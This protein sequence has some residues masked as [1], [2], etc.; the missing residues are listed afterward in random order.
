MCI[1]DSPSSLPLQFMMMRSLSE[2]YFCLRRF[3]THAL[4]MDGKNK[5]IDGRKRAPTIV[6][7][8]RVICVLELSLIHISEPTRLLSISYAVFC[9]KKKKKK[10]I[11]KKS[12]IIYIN[13]YYSYIIIKKKYANQQDKSLKNQKRD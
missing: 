6:F 4:K 9:L 3:C 1:R 12:Y 11:K 7:L 8:S 10:K 13:I 5:M 2:Y